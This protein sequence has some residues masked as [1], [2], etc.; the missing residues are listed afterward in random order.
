MLLFNLSSATLSIFFISFQ[1]IT[2]CYSTLPDY[3]A[4]LRLLISIHHMLLFNRIF[5][6]VKVAIMYFNTSHVIIQPK[7]SSYIN[8]NLNNFNTSHVVIQLAAL[9]LITAMI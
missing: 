7:P 1:C 3:Q 9:C 5:A 2:C 4:L 8:I 6:L